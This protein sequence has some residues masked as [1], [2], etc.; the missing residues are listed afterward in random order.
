MRA[1]SWLTLTVVVALAVP[2][3]ADG[4]PVRLEWKFDKDKTF[5]QTMSTVTSQKMKVMG[6]D[7]VQ[8]QKQ[9]FVFS[10]TPLANESNGD[11]IIRQK[12]EA[13]EMSIDIGG[14]KIEFDSAKPNKDNPLGEF[15]T[16]LVGT[17]FKLTIGRDYK[18]N[19]ID[20][21]EEFIKKLTTANPTMSTLLE[22]I[23]SEDALKQ[24]SDPVFAAIPGKEVKKG[25]KWSKT[26]MLNMGPIGSYETTY[27]YTF[28]GRDGDV[29]R[30]GCKAN[31]IYMAPN[32]NGKNALPFQIVSADLKATDA[33]GTVYFDLK[34]GRVEKSDMKLGLKGKMEIEIAGMKAE[35][36]LMQNQETTVTT[37]DDKPEKK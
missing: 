1:Q 32:K 17:E 33:K 36:E 9:V 4:D 8:E 10:W 27:D 3:Q 11:W 7:I 26:S 14:N 25:D 35:V 30:I 29:A 12:I 31:L 37:S 6:M 15:F 19:K 22:Q 23:L 5:Y 16:A 21:R 34:K 28:E 2:V 24:M 13:V 20:G 18:V